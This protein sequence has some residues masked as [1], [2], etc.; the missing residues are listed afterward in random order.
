MEFGCWSEPKQKTNFMKQIE[1]IMENFDFKKIHQYMLSSNWNWANEDGFHVPTIEQIKSNAQYLLQKV[2]FAN[3]KII[4]IGTGG[5][6]A[7]KFQN[8]LKLTF[9]ICGTYKSFND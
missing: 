9:E 4:D 5:F 7:Y 1:L 8:G 2:Y 3:E 6:T